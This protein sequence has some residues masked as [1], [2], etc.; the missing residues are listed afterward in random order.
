[1]IE[2]GE[3]GRLR[4]IRTQAEVDKS[5]IDDWERFDPTQKKYIL[6]AIEQYER[7]GQSPLLDVI[8]GAAY[9]YE[10]VPTR[11]FFTDPY[12]MG[13]RHSIYPKL[14]DD[15][16][17]IFDGGYH[18][19]VLSGCID[20]Q[21]TVH[22]AD[23]SMPRLWSLIG[24]ATK[25]TTLDVESG[26][27]EHGT[28]PGVDSGVRQVLSLQLRNGMRVKL[29][30]DHRVMTQRGWV[31]AAC[32]D[33]E[34]DF[35]VCPRRLTYEP[36]NLSLK[37]AEVKLLAYWTTDGSSDSGRARFC[38]GRIE[39][40]SEVIECLHEL[41]F[42]TTTGTPY[43]KNGAWEVHSKHFVGCGFRAW[44]QHYGV[45]HAPHDTI[46]VPDAIC[47]APL[48]QVALFLNRVWAAEGTVSYKG[49]SAARFQLAMKSRRFIEQ[50]QLLLLRFGIQSRV[51][52][53]VSRRHDTKCVCWTL[54]ISAKRDAELFVETIGVV[55]SKAR[56]TE[57]LLRRLSTKK[58]NTNVD[59]VPMR[60]GEANDFLIRHGI[61]RSRADPWWRLGTNRECYLSRSMFQEF[62]DRFRDHGAVKALETRFSEDVSFVRI[63]RIKPMRRPIP[64]AD[65]GVPGPSRFLASGLCVHNS[66]GWGKSYLSIMI[67]LRMLYEALGL[68]NPAEAYDLAP[69]TKIHFVNLSVRVDLARKVLF[70]GIGDKIKNSPF[71]SEL[72]FH[73]TKDEMRFPK[74]IIV[75][76]G[77]SSDTNV[78]GLNAFGGVMDETN[79]FAKKNM[80]AA[81][82][83][84]WGV[85]DTADRIYAAIMRRMKSRYQ[86]AGKLPGVLVMASSKRTVDDFTE[87][88]IREAK[89]DPS[90][91]YREY[92]LWDVA[93]EQYREK[94]FCIFVGNETRRSK[95]LEPEEQIEVPN[96]CRIIDVPEDFRDDF[97]RDLEGAIRDIAGVATVV[98]EPFIS[99]RE[100]VALI[101]DKAFKHPFS[102]E[103]W[104]CGHPLQPIWP[105]LFQSEGDGHLLVPICCPTEPRH[106]HVDPS[107]TKCATGFAVGHI[108]GAREVTRKD[109]GVEVTKRLPIVRFDVLLRILPPQGEEIILSDVVSLILMLYKKGLPIVSVTMDTYQSAGPRQE[110]A[111][112]GFEATVLSTEVRHGPYELMKQAIYEERVKSY[113]YEPLA[114]ELRSLEK[115]QRTG[116]IVFP[117][118]GSKDVA[119][120]AA[121]VVSYLTVKNPM[122]GPEIPTRRS[123]GIDRY[124][125]PGVT[126]ATAGSMPEWA[127]EE[128]AAEGSDGDFD[129]PFMMG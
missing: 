86:K 128:S 76:G 39:T 4:S 100:K 97:K 114:R 127:D 40:S 3:D 57:L 28:L 1:M 102:V 51:Y 107:L 118:G 25:V 109:Q 94:T 24:R 120:A 85:I 112:E 32:L 52:R 16:C 17:E 41:G 98:F 60:W 44:L 84:R 56:E 21:A 116:K 129:T 90:V 15:L 30:P 26:L 9:D 54:A 125:R 10:P 22:C 61:L 73:P 119:D 34:K 20:Q 37:D 83:A 58:S 29:T 71:F 78:L 126:T 91:F 19:V 23:G 45:F 13:P 115:D 72:G 59:V 62:C 70:E 64:V 104:I 67:M 89:D 81:N 50:V 93:R 36:S 92:A 31:P 14:L 113:P 99:M 42:E 87:R 47:R 110:L 6:Q 63:K 124:E 77:T 74:N 121:C 96:G 122:P 46:E 68:T 103:E 95:F 35:V 80:G 8:K 49:P 11:Q 48:R 105:R 108:C 123:S 55:F 38:D 53:T 101:E 65:I 2:V 43:P 33:T 117:P 18:E 7:T 82:M 106:A 27:E 69:N 111:R 75:T 5:F 79:F 88:R 12:F 66:I